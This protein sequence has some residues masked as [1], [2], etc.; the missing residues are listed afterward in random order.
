ML[1]ATKKYATNN[2]NVHL[3]DDA[4]SMSLLDL[5]DLGPKNKKAHRHF[6]VVVEKPIKFGLT[7]LEEKRHKQKKLTAEIS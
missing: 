7:A 5:I 3:I 4:W 1:P 2:T 6:P